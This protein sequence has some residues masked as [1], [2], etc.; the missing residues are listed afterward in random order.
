MPKLGNPD[1]RIR[2]TLLF[3]I[4]TFV[5]IAGKAAL[6]QTV[7]AA[8]LSKHDISIKHVE[9]IVTPAHRG[10][11]YDRN[12]NELAVGIQVKT[13]IANPLQV[14]D[15][16]KTASLLAPLLKMDP[17]ALQQ[18]LTSGK[19]AGTGFLYLA[20]KIDASVGDQVD[21]LVE[22]EHL[23]GIST[24]REEKRVYPQ[25]QLAAQ[26]I[27]YA[28]TDNN[29][30]AGMELQLDKVLRGTEGKQQ[31]IMAADGSQID[32]LSLQDGV[33]GK[34]VWLT[35]DESIQYET[36]KVL[37]DTVKQWHAKGAEA[38]VMNP[39]TGAIYAMASVP[40][41]DANNYP[42]LTN[43]ERRNR[44]VTD[45]YEPGSIFKAVTSAAA[46]EE[47][48]ITP[49][50]SFYL[51]PELDMGG[52]TIKDAVDRGPVNWDLGTILIHSSNIG[53][54]KV[55]MSVGKDK[56]SDW[57]NRFGFGVPTGIDFPG[58]TG[59]IVI[60]PN[61][62][63]ASTI[64]NVPIG[65]GIS[66]TPLQ[67]ATAY[68]TIAN[69]GIRPQPHLLRQEGDR[70]IAEPTGQRI[71]SAD[72]AGELTKLL[73]GVVADGGAPEAQIDG[74]KIA[75][76]TGTAQKIDPDGR[77]SNEN[78]IGSFVGYLPADDPQLLVLVKVDEPHPFG[79]GSTVAAPAFQKITKFAIGKLGITP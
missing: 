65:R 54:I 64:G 40:T 43:A 52:Y 6:L 49:T 79:G 44:P 8:D 27:G 23:P 51:P 7:N 39:R 32:T 31:V 61:R 25:N 13:V 28:G 57:I 5:I 60:P 17:Y 62:W 16:V 71:I 72:I 53:A 66:T 26:V 36:E 56:L 10:T 29:G 37:S 41:V 68:A 11:I 45:S 47:K 63:T 15:P 18:T 69:G 22:K 58:E 55:G 50:E 78:Y 76:K 9:E 3:F 21:Q 38:V 1:K 75:G 4:V 35:L 48:T 24:R 30:L 19:A 73:V 12:G 2:W 67:M 70:Q 14:Q 46:L 33:P 20:R 59:G 42:N 77:Y 34:D 74:F